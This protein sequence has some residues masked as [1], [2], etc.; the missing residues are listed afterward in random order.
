VKNPH[1][2]TTAQP[3]DPTFS[4]LLRVINAASWVV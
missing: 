2:W 3:T 1:I 4:E